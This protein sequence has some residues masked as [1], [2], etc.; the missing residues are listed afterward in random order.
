MSRERGGMLAT[1]ERWPCN[2]LT[3]QCVQMLISDIGWE[4]R[5]EIKLLQMLSNKIEIN[6]F[7]SKMFCFV[8]FCECNCGLILNAMAPPFLLLIRPPSLQINY[9]LLLI[10]GTSD[11]IRLDH[12]HETTRRKN[13]FSLSE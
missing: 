10:T 11:L 6:I 5:A 1:S 7:V 3:T 4:I 9:R 8:L 12:S 2:F 13:K